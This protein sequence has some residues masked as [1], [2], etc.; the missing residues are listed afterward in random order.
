[1]I[2][3]Y[4]IMSRSSNQIQNGRWIGWYGLAGIFLSALSL[5]A[6]PKP[7]PSLTQLKARAKREV[8]LQHNHRAVIALQRAVTADPH[9]KLGWW[10]LA[11]LLYQG[12]QYPAAAVA[13]RRLASLTPKV[14]LPWAMLGLCE[15]EQRNFENSLNHIQ[16]G[17]ALGLPND[18]NLQAVVI[19]H[20][21]Q[22]M[23]VLEEFDQANFIL[24]TFAV[25]HKPYP[26]AILAFG[27]AALHLGLASEQAEKILG[28][29]RLKLLQ[30]VGQAQYLAAEKKYAL[31][32]QRYARIIS[33]HPNLPYLHYAY[34]QILSNS[35]RITAAQSEYHKEIQ[36][37]PDGISARLQI[38]T[39]E[40]AM[41]N[42]VRALF[43]ARQS[44]KLQPYNFAAQFMMG[45]ILFRQNHPRQALPFILHSELLQPNNSQ[46]HY[47]LAQIYLHLHQMQAARREQKIF[48]RLHKIISRYMFTGVLPASVYL[49]SSRQPS[50][51]AKHKTRPSP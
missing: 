46:I 43:W 21:A 38:A 24:H 10:D 2:P 20:E 32:R 14:G 31:A 50:T 6:G 41:G 8:R 13:F 28:P 48:M 19:Y 37:N 47:L 11:D 4:S 9:W 23:L 42:L 7:Q 12:K 39:H 25:A 45:D 16:Q 1:M 22:D 15:F 26:G 51:R 33:H 49:P 36:I 29:A 3:H 5:L 44:L 40:I 27:L 30:A 18:A 34:G 17:R 35:G